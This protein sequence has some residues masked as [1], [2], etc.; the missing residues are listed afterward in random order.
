MSEP[1]TE[2]RLKEIEAMKGDN[3]ESV[4]KAKRMPQTAPTMASPLA[5]AGV[6][7]VWISRTIK[8][9]LGKSNPLRKQADDQK[10]SCG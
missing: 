2:A 8:D 1:M 9:R 5:L 6:G 7:C 3:S 10:R 4:R